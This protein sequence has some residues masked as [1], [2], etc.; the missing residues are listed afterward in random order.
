VCQSVRM[1][2]HFSHAVCHACLQPGDPSASETLVPSLVIMAHVQDG[3]SG[4][5]E[6]DRASL[7]RDGEITSQLN[8]QPNGVR[9]EHTGLGSARGHPGTPPAGSE[10]MAAGARLF[11]CTPRLVQPTVRAGSPARPR[12]CAT[13]GPTRRMRRSRFA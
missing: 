5:T 2:S 10:P 13:P 8:P 12:R 3:G 1:N 4:P 11:P 9:F 7:G 6:L